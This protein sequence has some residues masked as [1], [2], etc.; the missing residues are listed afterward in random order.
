MNQQNTLGNIGGKNTANLF[1]GLIQPQQQQISPFQLLGAM[2][3]Q[4]KRPGPGPAPGPAINPLGAL[5]GPPQP[6]SMNPSPIHVGPQPQ[7]NAFAAM[8][9]PQAQP[10]MGGMQPKMNPMNQMFGGGGLYG[11]N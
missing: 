8:F 7:N 10:M 11:M 4:P 1:A 9:A 2:H 3:Q 5:M 6:Q